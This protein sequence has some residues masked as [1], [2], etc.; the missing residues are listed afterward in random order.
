MTSWCQKF[1]E[2]NK[3]LLCGNVGPVLT[4][5]LVFFFF[6]NSE[7]I[8]LIQINRVQKVYLIYSVKRNICPFLA[9]NSSRIKYGSWADWNHQFLCFLSFTETV[10]PTLLYVSRDFW[11]G[12]F[13]SCCD[14]RREW[15]RE[16]KRFVQVEFLS[17]W[18]MIGSG[19]RMNVR[20]WKQNNDDYKWSLQTWDRSSCTE[21]G[22]ASGIWYNRVLKLYPRWFSSWRN[23][24]MP[25]CTDV[26]L[27]RA[28]R[29]VCSAL[30]QGLRSAP[31]DVTHRYDV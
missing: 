8:Y 24:E 4:N 17:M 26:A 18:W 9:N 14:K 3:L 19:W 1:L 6:W 11:L 22:N 15:L 28:W 25:G 21:A 31:G 12:C 2:F 30:N 16:Y 5:A 27:P 13:N 10:I 20:K 7:H 29:W 23:K